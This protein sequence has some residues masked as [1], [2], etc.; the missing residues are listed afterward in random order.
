MKGPEVS[1]QIKAALAAFE[2]SLDDIGGC[3]DSSCLVRKPVGMAT[4]GGCRCFKSDS[5]MAKRMAMATRRFH[6]AVKAA[7]STP[8][9]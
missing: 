2:A 4:N 1:D 9:T 6:S 7:T 5:F 3:G 8:T